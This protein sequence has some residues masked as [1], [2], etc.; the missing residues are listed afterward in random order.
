M[1]AF[2]I[3]WIPVPSTPITSAV[4][5]PQQFDKANVGR[6]F[7]E[8]VSTRNSF[9]ELN[10]LFEDYIVKFGFCVRADGLGIFWIQFND[11]TV[12]EACISKSESVVRRLI[13]DRFGH[14]HFFYQNDLKTGI[15]E[16]R[17]VR[18]QSF[19]VSYD[20]FSG[21]LA[22][23]EVAAGVVQNDQIQ[24]DDAL[25][26]KE[27][28]GS[29]EWEH[30]FHPERVRLV[31]RNPSLTTRLSVFP[32][33][34]SPSAKAALF[35]IRRRYSDIF[36]R[37]S[38]VRDEI[39]GRRIVAH[40]NSIVALIFVLSVSA[41]LV[42]YYSNEVKAVEKDELVWLWFEWV[43]KLFAAAVALASVKAAISFFS[44]SIGGI[45]HQDRRAKAY[46]YSRATQKVFIPSIIVCGSLATLLSGDTKIP[47][48]DWNFGFGLSF[49]EVD[50]E[51]FAKSFFSKPYFELFSIVALVGV[52]VYGAIDIHFKRMP[53]IKSGRSAIANL[54]YGDI[55]SRLCADEC[56]GK[57]SDW[58]GFGDARLI[59]Q[60]YMDNEKAK[61]ENARV[62][63]VLIISVISFYLFV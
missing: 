21:A 23:L 52:V 34:S 15:F 38:R 27:L 29:D 20:D 62:L 55:F 40:M 6:F 25:A 18:I 57:Y 56:N 12:D 59:V 44:E 11:E 45:E 46:K 43:F 61:L 53:L 17:S 10:A 9:S 42:A 16:N 1:I 37:L 30:L 2:F 41:P 35:Q 22:A 32:S 63:Y 33:G 60:T 19:D 13:H 47:F 48:T 4:G 51:D 50:G 28:V 14:K 54:H 24:R 3:D 7:R 36:P 8:I 31:L 39:R 26:N 5:R 49:T 58:D